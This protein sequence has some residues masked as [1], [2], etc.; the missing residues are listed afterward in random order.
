MQE[1][2]IAQFG[3][4]NNSGPQPSRPVGSFSTSPFRSQ[5]TNRPQPT[6]RPLS[7]TRSQAQNTSQASASVAPLA[8]TASS[9]SLSNPTSAKKSPRNKHGLKIL[10]LLLGLLTTTFLVTTILLALK[11]QE[12]A[13]AATEE[14]TT[15]SNLSASTL[16]FFPNKIENPAPST[17]YI[18]V[19]SQKSSTGNT[20]LSFAIGE[21][22]SAVTLDINWEFV[23]DYYDLS[24]ARTDHETFTIKFSQ[25][26][27]QVIIGKGTAQ[28]ADEVALFLLADGTVEYL[29]IANCLE[30]RSFDSYGQLGGLSE[31]VKF[32]IANTQASSDDS[33]ETT[34]D[35][36]GPE[37]ILA[38]KANGSLFDLKNLLLSAVSK[39]IQQ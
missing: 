15:F 26:V 13:P 3:I 29:P 1:K 6:S 35:S 24:V 5:M 7:T 9:A 8:N 4:S 25:P 20:V 16:G 39:D 28:N 18:Y 23:N 14:D 12:P 33:G 17:S 2:N 22:T 10:C 38:Q 27:A 11:K 30:Y 32:Y 37:T 36:Q 21:E 19:V 31:V 34:V